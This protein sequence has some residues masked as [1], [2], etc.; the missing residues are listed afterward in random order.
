MKAHPVLAPFQLGAHRLRNR[1]VVAPLSRVSAPATGVPTAAMARYYAE[2]A[3]GGFGLVLSEGTYTDADYAQAY[4]HQPGLINENQVAGWHEV[5]NRVHDAGAKMFCQLMHA[6]ALSQCLPQTGG[7]SPVRPLRH[8]LKD[9]GGEGPWPI[10]KA[11]TAQEID[12]AVAGFAQ[13]AQRAVA[14]GFDGVEIHGANGYWIDQFLTHTTNQRQDRYGGSVAARATLALDTIAA[15]KRVV[16]AGFTVGLRLSQGKVN[17]FDYQWPDSQKTART[18]FS[19][20]AESGVDYLH[21]A[22]EG[23]G[24]QHGCVLKDG[25]VLPQLARTLV[26]VPVIVNGGMHQPHLAAQVLDDEQGDLV[27]LGTGAL[28]NP[29]WPNKLALGEKIQPFQPEMLWPDVTIES[30][31]AWRN[32]EATAAQT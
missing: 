27:A 24:Y 16:P 15:V 23:R 20:L 5:V 18:W 11:M 22:S 30:T 28:A 2:F 32:Q 6:G 9:Y 26:G 7:P 12:R 4:T 8:K 25:T 14:A 17:D 29:D 31:W 10:P 3:Q 19:L 13:A 21:F 1:A